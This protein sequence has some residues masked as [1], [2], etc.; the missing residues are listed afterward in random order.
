MPHSGAIIPPLM[1]Q[2][3]VVKGA[4]EHNLKNI[5]VEIPRDKPARTTLVN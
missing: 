5:E 2:S 4:R 1:G 3:I